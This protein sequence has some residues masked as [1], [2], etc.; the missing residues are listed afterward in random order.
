MAWIQKLQQSDN[1]YVCVWLPNQKRKKMI[2]TGT[3]DIIQAEKILARITE[4]EN[5]RK[6]DEKIIRM[7]YADIQYDRSFLNDIDEVLEIDKPIK[8][9]E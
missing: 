3:D 7:L 8:D 5:L 2:S 6:T 9:G 4:I 1:Y